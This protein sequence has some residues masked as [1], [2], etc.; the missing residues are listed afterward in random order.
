MPRS[1]PPTTSLRTSPSRWSPTSPASPLRPASRWATPGRSSPAPPARRRP[2]RRRSRSMASA[3]ARAR[4]R[5][6]SSPPKRSAR[7]RA[8][9]PAHGSGCPARGA[10]AKLSSGAGSA[11]LLLAQGD[12]L[13]ARA[14]LGLGD[15][16][17]LRRR[18]RLRS[19]GRN[20]RL[21]RRR[22][23]CGA[24]PALDLLLVDPPAEQ[25][26][27]RPD[28]LL[29][30][31][32][33]RPGDDLPRVDDPEPAES[34]IDRDPLLRPAPLAAD[35][36]DLAGS[37]L[38]EVLEV[39]AVVLPAVQVL[40][41]RPF[42]LPLAPDQVAIQPGGALIP[43]NQGIG[44]GEGDLAIA[45]GIGLQRDPNQLERRRHRATVLPTHRP[46]K[47]PSRSVASL[48]PDRR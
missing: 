43:A 1:A 10:A 26:L 4:R 6:R 12:G 13:L 2:R 35:A 7:R 24:G 23:S 25:L 29:R 27:S 34:A 18:P 40:A 32:V 47:L 9:S 44:E 38:G 45:V 31:Q 17:L 30:R 16:R 14:G 21:L 28:R 42:H 37:D 39:E 48:P 5:P 22:P 8:G 3:S 33:G 46:L 36:Y 11:L 20:G 41:H 19:P 15:L